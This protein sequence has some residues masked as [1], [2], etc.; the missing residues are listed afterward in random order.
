MELKEA[1]FDAHRITEKIKSLKL[2]KVVQTRFQ[3][4]KGQKRRIY[5]EYGNLYS[6]WITDTFP[7]R[8]CN[9]YLGAE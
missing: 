7:H 5:K 4:Q 3:Y 9:L 1:I 6:T 8:D 2:S